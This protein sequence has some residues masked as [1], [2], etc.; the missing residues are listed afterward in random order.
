MGSQ[1]SEKSDGIGGAW[2]GDTYT[3]GPIGG[4]GSSGI[5]SSTKK[6]KDYDDWRTRQTNSYQG[7]GG[8][9]NLENYAYGGGRK[10]SGYDP[11]MKKSDGMARYEEKRKEE[12]VSR[13]KAAQDRREIFGGIATAKKATAPGFANRK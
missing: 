6:T 4:F 2:A 9:S 3:G 13:D 11:Y 8:L 10:E 12:T 7:P 5:G 1:K